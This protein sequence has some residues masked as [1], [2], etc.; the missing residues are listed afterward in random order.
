[1]KGIILAAGKGTR[2]YPITKG[3]AKSILPVYDQPIL[4]YPIN[5]LKKGGV[6]DII[7]VCSAENA[8]P[9]MNVFGSGKDWGVNLTYIPQD[10]AYGTAGAV[11]SAKG[12]AEGDKIAVILGDNIIDYNQEPEIK[13]FAKETGAKLFVKEVSDPSRFG[14]VEIKDGKVKSIEEKPS[15][16]KSNYAIVGIYV[17]PKDVFAKLEKV[18]P[19]SRGELELPD[20]LNMY[21]KE[22]KLKAGIL[23]GYWADVGT[24]DG[25]LDAS[26]WA[27]HKKTA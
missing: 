24:F 7:I 2:L 16:P 4:S 25:L 1:M 6:T 23:K 3:A 22:G 5:I 27:A 19:S 12:F 13:N 17:F 9:Y 26:E 10:R 21:L 20:V 8:G 14:V 15:K 18:K 11:L